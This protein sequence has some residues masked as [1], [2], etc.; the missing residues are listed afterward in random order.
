MYS[1]TVWITQQTEFNHFPRE[2]L[3][4]ESL[5]QHLF[6]GRISLQPGLPEISSPVEC[7]KEYTQWS[8]LIILPSR[9]LSRLTNLIVS[10]NML[11]IFPQHNPQGSNPHQRL[12]PR[13]A[14]QY[15]IPQRSLFLQHR[16]SN[17]II[18]SAELFKLAIL[19]RVIIHLELGQI[20]H[21]RN[22]HLFYPQSGYTRVQ[23]F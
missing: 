5:L 9:S 14:I 22:V 2:F 17:R 19:R 23:S 12:L 6:Y 11:R 20:V 16:F 13:C 7:L 3:P 15:S 8:S 18:S 21:R 1:P 10:L 4:A